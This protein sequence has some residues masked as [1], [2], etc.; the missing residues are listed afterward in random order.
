MLMGLAIG[1]SFTIDAY[2]NSMKYTNKSAK[3]CSKKHIA[4]MNEIE[5]RLH[6]IKENFKESGDVAC[7]NK[8]LDKIKQEL[9]CVITK[10]KRNEEYIRMWKT[11]KHT[12]E[13]KL[14]ET[15]EF[16]NRNN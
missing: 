3:S 10:M 5:D 9:P 16:V 14:H 6:A 8:K 2:N 13:R 1:S 11:H 12:L 15:R 7:A 4:S